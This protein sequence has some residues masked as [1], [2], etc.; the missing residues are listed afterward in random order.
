MAYK[1]KVEGTFE[2]WAIVN[3]N[4]IFS[5]HPTKAQAKQVYKDTNCAKHIKIIKLSSDNV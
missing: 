2:A 3:N 5:V 4:Y 1:Q